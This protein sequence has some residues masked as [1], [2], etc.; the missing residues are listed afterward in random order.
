MFFLQINIGRMEFDCAKAKGVLDKS[1]PLIKLPLHKDCSYPDL[2]SKCVEYVWGEAGGDEYNYYVADGGGT[3][4][5]S[6]TFEVS[7]PNGD[8]KHTLPWT[9]KNYLQVSSVRYPSRLRLYCVR[10]LKSGMSS[11]CWVQIISCPVVYE[12]RQWD[13]Y[14]T[15]KCI[16]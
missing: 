14:L 15:S 8:G 9:L 16:L 5:G 3:S 7:A 12:G 4:I 13:R 1:F 10:K 6:S 11:P 2:L